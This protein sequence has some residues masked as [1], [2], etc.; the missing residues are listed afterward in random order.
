MYS[1]N[2]ATQGT[3]TKLMYNNNNIRTAIAQI[4]N[5][6]V[7]SKVISKMTR[8][9]G[10]VRLNV[11]GKHFETFYNT[12]HR[13]PHTLLGTIDTTSKYYCADDDEYFFDR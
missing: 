2:T 1:N 9:S 3:T 4:Q 7:A 10:R 6:D 13:Y 8:D 11:G 5:K 12:I